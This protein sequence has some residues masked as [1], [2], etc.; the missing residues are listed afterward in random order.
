MPLDDVL[1]KIMR[2]PDL[3]G[4]ARA[5]NE[6]VRDAEQLRKEAGKRRAEALRELSAAGWAG[7]DIARLLGVSRGRVSQIL[8]ETTEQRT[9]RV[10]GAENNG[11]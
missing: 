8:N 10:R 3:E 1:E 7:K 11:L 2:E 9:R 5:L 6:L 4:R